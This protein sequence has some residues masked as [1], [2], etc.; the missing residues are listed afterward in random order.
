M[1]VIE[2]NVFLDNDRS[3]SGSYIEDVKVLSFL[4]FASN[5]ELNKNTVV[6]LDNGRLSEFFAELCS[7]G[8]PQDRIYRTPD[9]VVR[10]AFGE[11]YFDLFKTYGKDEVFIDAGSYNGETTRDFIKWCNGEYKKYMLL[12]IC[13]MDFI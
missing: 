8:Y 6:I 7:L 3:K 13:K 4:E 2:L 12:N 9:N 10:T 5:E 1:P 11:I